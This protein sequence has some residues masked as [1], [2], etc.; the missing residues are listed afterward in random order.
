MTGG[1][2]GCRVG[3]VGIFPSHVGNLEHSRHPRHPFDEHSADT[4]GATLHR[5]HS[6]THTYRW[7]SWGVHIVQHHGIVLQYADTPPRH[8]PD[9]PRHPPTPPTPPTPPS[10]WNMLAGR[11]DVHVKHCHPSVTLLTMCSNAASTRARASRRA[12]APRALDD[13]TL[14]G[15][16]EGVTNAKPKKGETQSS[17]AEAPD[18]SKPKKSGRGGYRTGMPGGNP[19]FRA[20]PEHMRGTPMIALR[21]WPHTHQRWKRYAAI[22]QERDGATVAEVFEAM[23][24]ALE[25]GAKSLGRPAEELMHEAIVANRAKMAKDE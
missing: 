4:H 21:A 24:D 9:T 11:G 22:C 19:L 16:D 14:V 15:Y 13:K 7:V 5:D 20:M 25:A 23:L 17:G 6:R 3:G 18:P 1:D 12:C 8:P 10:P 2:G